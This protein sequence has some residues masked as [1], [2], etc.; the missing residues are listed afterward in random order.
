MAMVRQPASLGTPIGGGSSWL[1]AILICTCAVHMRCVS[2]YI[3]FLHTNSTLGQ[4]SY[5]RALRPSWFLV[6]TV[7]GMKFLDNPHNLRMKR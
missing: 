1:F 5:G 3:P 6:Q 7:S 4:P 2:F